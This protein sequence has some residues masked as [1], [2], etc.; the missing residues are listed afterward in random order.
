MPSRRTI[1]V[2][3]GFGGLAAAIRLAAAGDS[4]EV[5][6]Q[7]DAIGGRAGT[8]RLTSALGEH[9]FDAGPTVLTVPQKFDDLFALAGQRLADHVELVPLDPMYRVFAPDGR[10]LDY[11]RDPAAMRAEVARISPADV[12][13]F[14]RLVR[15]A[16]GIFDTLYPF[17]ERDMMNPAL[18]LG[19]LPYLARHR[20][21]VP[22]YPS[23]AGQV[24]DPFVRQA[25]SFHPLLIG[26]NPMRTPALYQLI[27]H[28]ER[29]E[30]VHYAVGG[31]TALV[32]A[33]GRLLEDLGGKVRLGT[34]VERILVDSD[35]S[36]GSAIGVRL[37]DG[38]TELADTVV[39]NADAATAT[40]TLL[41]GAPTPRATAASLR[42]ATLRPSMSLAVL[43]LGLER[44]YPHT[45]LRHHSVL[46]TGDYR[47]A[48]R[49]V[50]SGRGWSSDAI[51]DDL[52]LYAHM[53]SLTDRS[54]A[55]DGG[56]TLYVLAAVPSGARIDWQQAAPLLREKIL[57]A[58]ARHLPGLRDHVGAEHMV[59]PRYFSGEL[60]SA[61]GA[62]FASAPTLMQSGWF[63][64]HNRSR[65]ARG[66]YFVGAGVHPGAGVPAVLAS[67]RIA[68]DLVQRDRAA[69]RTR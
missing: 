60:S 26:G 20:A 44:R 62:A 53:P 54:V 8:V 52:F 9:V 41:D 7:R 45:D 39:C 33:F 32:A 46:V 22:V 18:M 23:V 25:L 11:H 58:L 31:T 15:R 2:G 57:D 21:F 10:H 24:K 1:V 40:R 42:A 51:P 48:I 30:G 19:M 68:A 3:S 36:R 65:V 66:L 12:A 67:G 14:G 4:V 37:Q 55:P 47:R 27:P 29:R 34:R 49:G 43:Y 16:E 61:H 13:G 17:T 50:F 35:G 59:D 38:T 56:E 64:P 63:R 28:L 6:E 5:L 69:G